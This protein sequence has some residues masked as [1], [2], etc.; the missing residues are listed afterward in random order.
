[1]R[2]VMRNLNEERKHMKVISGARGTGK[3]TELINKAADEELYI[4]CFSREEADRVAN[5]AAKIGKK[6]PHPITMDELIKSQFHEIGI[7]G[8]LIDNG[9]VLLQSLARSVPVKAV[10]FTDA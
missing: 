6:I 4:V 8:F 1:M 5:H 3:T 2:L 9:D 10:T 7:K